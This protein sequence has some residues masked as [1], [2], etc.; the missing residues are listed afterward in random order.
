MWKD[1]FASGLDFLRSSS[2]DK[3]RVVC[4]RLLNMIR[5]AKFQGIEYNDA[6]FGSKKKRREED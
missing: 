1:V 6:I 2:N 5:T 4:T 3:Q